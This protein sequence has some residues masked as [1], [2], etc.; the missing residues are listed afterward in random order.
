MAEPLS[1]IRR[2]SQGGINCDRLPATVGLLQRRIRV[3]GVRLQTRGITTQQYKQ[4]Q[5]RRRMLIIIGHKRDQSVELPINLHVLRR[6]VCMCSAVLPCV[7]KRVR[8]HLCPL[9]EVGYTKQLIK[10][11]M[12]ALPTGIAL[13]ESHVCQRAHSHAH[14]RYTKRTHLQTH[15]TRKISV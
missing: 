4:G 2:N 12:A 8:Q 3:T 13:C 6:P 14:T 10:G 7:N 15:T 11:C 9:R 5:S 1:D